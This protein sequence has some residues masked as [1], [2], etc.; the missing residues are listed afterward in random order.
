MRINIPYGTEKIELSVP[1]RNIQD[2]IRSGNAV[3][4]TSEKDI[5]EK[6][7]LNPV[8]SPALKQI[9]R[10][11]NT[12]AILV[13]D[14]TRP[15]P[16]YKFLPYIINELESG[17]I[18]LSNMKII[19]ALGTH[20]GLTD[21]ERKRLVGDEAFNKVKVID[22]DSQ[23][24]VSMGTTAAGTPV[25]LFKEAVG[26]DL[27]ICTGNIEYH[28]F[29]GYSGGAKAVMP[30]MS[31]KKSIRANH[32]MMLDENAAAGSIEDNPVRV[33]IEEVGRMAG[34]DF[35]FNVVLDDRKNIIGAAAG[36]NNQAWLEAIKRYDDVYMV[37]VGSTADIVIASAG[38]YPRDLNLY[39][40]HKALENVKDIA[41]TGGTIILAASCLEGFGNDVFKEWMDDVTD[42]DLI[43]SRIR[44][45]FILG[46]HK[47][48]AIA[49]I[50]KEK[51]V[52]LYSEFDR[53]ATEKMGF[54]KI[55]D[56]Q[57]YLDRTIEEDKDIKITVVPCGRFVKLKK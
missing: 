2:I 8:Q 46:G 16:S 12:V 25:E 7:L 50:I 45:E 42:Y 6:A 55:D 13:S 32:R 49:R 22:S 52:L 24:V 19:I 11:K 27:L 26:N 41:R 43:D 3:S 57:S 56:I 38:G 37:E 10:G 23:N 1:E 9:A 21:K 17:G 34:I 14:I 15:C 20:R 29:A 5:I 28:Y 30:G 31:T 39:Q 44:K 53:L 36:K 48:V 47:A 51:K 54:E 40:A 35:I 18:L 33:D 4:A